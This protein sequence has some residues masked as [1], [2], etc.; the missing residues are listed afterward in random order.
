MW[1]FVT[2]GLLLVTSLALVVLR[3]VRP[4]SQYAWLAGAFGSI[5]VW[6]SVF[7]WQLEPGL[8]ISP[9]TWQPATLFGNSPEFIVDATGWLFAISLTAMAAAIILTAPARLGPI[10]PLAWAGTLAITAIGLLAVTANNPLTLVL[11]WTAIDFTEFASALRSA[12]DSS[13][14]ERTVVAFGMRSLGSGLAMW[15]LANGTVT[16]SFSAINEQTALLLLFAAGMRLGVLPLHLPF[17]VEPALRRGLGT[18]MRM[19][20][21]ATSLVLLA[22]IS[23]SA[24]FLVTTVLLGLSSLAA[25]YGGWKW[26]SVSDELAA[27]PYWIVTVAA[28]AVAAALRGNPLGSAAF[29]SALVLF[30]ALTFL[31]SSRSRLLSWLLVIPALGLASLPFTLTAPAWLGGEGMFFIFWPF[32][33]LAQAFLVVGYVRHALR[34][35]EDV[36]QALPR[37]A[38]VSYPAGLGILVLTMLQAGLWGWPGALQLGDW[39][40]GLVVLLLS[41]IMIFILLRLPGLNTSVVVPGQVIISRFAVVQDAL[42]GYLWSTYVLIGRLFGFLADL[43]EGD[44][45]LLWT[46]LL[47]VLIFSIVQVP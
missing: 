32:L 4:A 40:A 33:L 6:V 9:G 10:S 12:R 3:F 26:L 28:L 13:A 19:T 18:T 44:G 1:I 36:F 17:R 41:G 21:A 46:L 11:V 34:P 42:A 45:G 22:R 39:W 5:F 8:S 14:S 47:L 38:Q 37:W 27:R 2:F 25:L 31:Y 30:G 24:N 7:L 29:G 23:F 15:S 20:A 16:A 35:T 43:L